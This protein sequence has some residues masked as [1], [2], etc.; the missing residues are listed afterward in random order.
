MT[1]FVNLMNKG[2]T[3]IGMPQSLNYSFACKNCEVPNAKTWMDDLSAEADEDEL[4]EK[5]TLTWRQ[6]N[7]FE[8]GSSLYPLV[9]NRLVPDVAFMVGPL[10]ETK[11]WTKPNKNVDFLFLLRNDIESVHKSK[12]NK[13]VI[14]GIIND[15]VNTQGFSFDLVDWED[16]ARFYQPLQNESMELQFKY[17]VKKLIEMDLKQ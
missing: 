8:S 10:E 15:N 11:V 12:R 2:K 5:I 13:Q 3:I 16:R 4:R 6:D 1:S 14:E 17:K 9:D 7:S